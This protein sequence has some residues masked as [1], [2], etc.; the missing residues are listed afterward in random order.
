MV[1]D[2]CNISHDIFLPRRKIMRFLLVQIIRKNMFEY[3]RAQGAK[4]LIFRLEMGV[5]CAAS[6]IRRIY[7]LL[8]RYI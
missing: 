2:V 7:D 4:Q 6:D 1:Q 5:K 8:N 3:F